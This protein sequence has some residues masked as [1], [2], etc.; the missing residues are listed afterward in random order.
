MSQTEEVVVDLTSFDQLHPRNDDSFLVD[1]TKRANA[2]RRAATHID[3]VRETREVAEDLPAMKNRRDQRDVVQ[4]HAALKRVVDKQ[5]VAGSEPFRAVVPDHRGYEAKQAAQV[6]RL[7]ECLRHG[8]QVAVEE[9]AGEITARLDIAG[10][11]RALEGDAHLVDGRRQ[12]VLDDLK[13]DGVAQKR[14]SGESH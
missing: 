12:R 4:M 10:I 6:N 5:P 7:G 9:H 14:G 11:R 13:A 1:L 8:P 3:V 2:R